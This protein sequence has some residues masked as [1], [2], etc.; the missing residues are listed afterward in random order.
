[1]STASHVLEALPPATHRI[2]FRRYRTQDAA[3]V[4][5]MFGDGQARR[6]YPHMGEPGEVERWIAWSLDNY[7]A[8][9]LG[10]WVIESRDEGSFLGD[11]GL[12]YQVVEG[13]PWLEV[14]Y[15]LGEQHRGKGYAIEAARACVTYAL[16]Q[17]GAERVCS[18]VDPANTPSIRVASRVHHSSRTFLH[19]SGEFRL[20]FWSERP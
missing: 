6:F 4:A 17:V 2:R 7:G 3:A 19:S 14:G 5:E 15:H 8:H 10:L 18:I 16:E 20:L 11:C 13:E 12:T 1:M 9:G